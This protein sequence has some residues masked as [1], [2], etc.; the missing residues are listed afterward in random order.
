[1]HHTKPNTRRGNVL[2][3]DVMIPRDVKARLVKMAQ[4]E[5]RSMSELCSCLLASTETPNQGNKP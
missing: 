3:L 4:A 5:Q 1:M 2:R